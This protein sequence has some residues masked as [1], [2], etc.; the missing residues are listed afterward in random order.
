MRLTCGG[1]LI[2]LSTPHW[3][4]QTSKGGHTKL[5]NQVEINAVVQLPHPE[6]TARGLEHI[7]TRI[8][9]LNDSEKSGQFCKRV[10][11]EKETCIPQYS[12]S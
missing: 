1:T 2:S 6:Y 5:H 7:R 3:A 12:R 10:R 4:R 11:I 8:D 9:R